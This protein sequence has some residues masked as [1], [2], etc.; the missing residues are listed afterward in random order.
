MEALEISGCPFCNMHIHLEQNAINF[1]MGPS[2]AYM[3]DDV[4]MKTNQIGFC[5]EHYIQLHAT[6]NRL[7]LALMLH[8]HMT[9]VLS[10]LSRIYTPQQQKLFSKKSLKSNYLEKLEKSCYICDMIENSFGRMIDTFFGLFVKEEQAKEL[11]IKGDGFC[12][13]HLRHA[14]DEA[15]SKLSAAKQKEFFVHLSVL[16]SAQ[17]SKIH[18][19]LD[20]FIKKFDYR[21][22]NEDWKDA[23]DAPER[24]I[25]RLTGLNPISHH[26]KDGV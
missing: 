5:K 19:D 24:A 4:R 17:I 3:E 10:E 9:E 21:Y 25:E 1:L 12:L 23:K 2:V 20:W 16:Q 22:Q 15:N 8:T 18:E 11:L 13:P 6:K 26:K 14:I 7:G